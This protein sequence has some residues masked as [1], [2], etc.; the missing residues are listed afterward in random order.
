MKPINKL[1]KRLSLY[2]FLILFTFQTSSQADDIRDFQI[3]GM[4]IGDS[5]LDYLSEKEILK[6]LEETKDQ[7]SWTDKKFGD[8]YIYKETENYEYASVSVKKKDKKYIIYAARGM[9]DY[10]DVN[11]CFKKQKEI[12]DQ[13]QETFRNAKKT[14]NT[15][16]SSADPSGESLIHAIYF[17]FGSGGDIQVTC[18]EFSKKIKSPNGLDVAISS[19]EHNK[20]LSKF[21]TH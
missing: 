6:A 11:V 10:E 12:S 18:Y 15:F 5:L 17:N 1:M 16:K 21:Y 4:S 19:E 8:V 9:I 14:K 13:I 3:A 20:W 7:Y 2:L